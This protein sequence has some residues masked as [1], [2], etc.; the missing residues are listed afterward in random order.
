MPKDYNE[1]DPEKG[2][3]DDK[4]NR[5]TIETRSYEI[6]R[7]DLGAYRLRAIETSDAPDIY[8][9]AGSD[10]TSRFLAWNTH[11]NVAETMRYIELVSKLNSEKK[12]MDWALEEKKTG[13]VVGTVTAV[14]RSRR[15]EVMELGYVIH[16]DFRDR[17]IMTCAVRAVCG[18]LFDNT[19]CHRIE[20]KTLPD[21]AASIRVLEKTGFEYEGMKKKGQLF[22]AAWRDILVYSLLRDAWHQMQPRDPQEGWR[23]VRR[24]KCFALDM[25]GT[26]Y[27]GDEVLPG[28]IELIRYLRENGIRPV[29]LTNNSSR[30]IDTYV[31]RLNGMGFDV[32]REDILSSGEAAAGYL[33]AHYPGKRVYVM[34]NENLKHEIAQ[35]GIRVT[36]REAEVVLSGCVAMYGNP[37]RT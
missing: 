14:A 17:G 35:A 33:L 11:R 6:A 9:Y 18:Y 22:H 24:A 25:D 8:A 32:K 13:R 15:G 12:Q 19:L 2:K 7:F 3:H 31:T 21:N 1:E 37:A 16:P 27:L 29:F 4:E 23:K 36:E 30:N 28:A 34:G 20:A 10:E 5:M 26:V